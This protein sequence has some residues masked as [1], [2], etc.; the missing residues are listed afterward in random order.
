MLTPAAHCGVTVVI[1]KAIYKNIHERRIELASLK[2][3]K[4]CESF[5]DAPVDVRTIW[6]YGKGTIW[7]YGTRGDMARHDMAQWQSGHMA[8]D[9]AMRPRP[10]M[11][12][13]PAK[14]PA[15]AVKTLGQDTNAV[16]TLGQDTN[17]V[18]S[19]CP[20]HT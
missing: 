3:P 13:A 17:A 8:G 12:I 7:R 2:M 20:M 14:A 11:K 10:E 18:S 6:R 15:N 19:Q 4:R 9:M 1:K 16:K 5:F